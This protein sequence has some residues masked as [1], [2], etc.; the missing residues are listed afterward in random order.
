ME[1][2]KRKISILVPYR[3]TG[4]DVAVFFG[5]G[6]EG[7]ENPEQALIRE[8]KEELDF[9]PL[10]N[11]FFRK[12]EFEGSIKHIF[13]IGVE[14]SFDTKITILEGQ[15]GRWFNRSEVEEEPKL[16]EEDKIVLRDLYRY[17]LMKK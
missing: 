10:G 17:L 13:I 15:Y 11:N 9:E 6:A 12:Y 2:K 7:Q 1:G 5:G 16:I 8:I 3:R 14:E 4:H